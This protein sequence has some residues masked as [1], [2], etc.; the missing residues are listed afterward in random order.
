MNVRFIFYFLLVIAHDVA[1]VFNTVH[2][3]LVGW[4]AVEC[5]VYA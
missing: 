1:G 3:I 4:S 2:S 5:Y